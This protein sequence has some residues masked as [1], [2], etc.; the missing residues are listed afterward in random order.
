[1]KQITRAEAEPCFLQCIHNTVC[2]D[3]YCNVYHNTLTLSQLMEWQRST[4]FTVKKRTVLQTAGFT[5]TGHA[6]YD[7][8]C[9]MVGGR[10]W[11]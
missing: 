5:F 7:N 2:Y 11:S 3:M 1:M 9:V 4:A 8:K 6:Q 10:V